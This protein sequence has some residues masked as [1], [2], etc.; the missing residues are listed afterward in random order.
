[1]ILSA[2]HEIVRMLLAVV[3]LHFMVAFISSTKQNRVK[4][5]KNEERLNPIVVF[6][7][8]TFLARL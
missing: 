4:T 1:M 7:R 2:S 3:R 5:I 6:V 8:S